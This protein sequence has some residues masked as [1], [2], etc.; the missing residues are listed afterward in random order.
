VL[1][2]CAA[3]A[4]ALHDAKRQIEETEVALLVQQSSR[5]LA[6]EAGSLAEI[7]GQMGTLQGAL[8][9]L[10]TQLE[11]VPSLQRGGSSEAIIAQLVRDVRHQLLGAMATQSGG[12][13]IEGQPHAS[14]RA[15]AAAVPAAQ[16]GAGAGM[17]TGA[18]APESVELLDV[19]FAEAVAPTKDSVAVGPSMHLQYELRIARSRRVLGAGELATGKWKGRACCFFNDWC[20]R[21]RGATFYACLSTEVD[22]TVSDRQL[23]LRYRGEK[24]PE[25]QSMDVSEIANSDKPRKITLTTRF[26]AFEVCCLFIPPACYCMPTCFRAE[27]DLWLLPAALAK[28]QAPPQD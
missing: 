28:A 26:S 20:C 12:V 4:A 5:A 8:K 16:Y 10:C 27:L 3:I 6:G 22:A 19:H 2:D 21:D 9:Q 7:I 18:S 13:Q 23:L 25:Q 1:D 11:A 24:G 17:A 14:A 15:A